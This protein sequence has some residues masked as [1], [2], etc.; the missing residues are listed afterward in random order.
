M[1]DGIQIFAGP[2]WSTVRQKF[3]AIHKRFQLGAACNDSLIDG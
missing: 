2:R 3:N 1:A